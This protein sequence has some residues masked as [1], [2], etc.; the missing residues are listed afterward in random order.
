[1]QEGLEGQARG[2]KWDKSERDTGGLQSHKD[3]SVSRDDEYRGHSLFLMD[4]IFGRPVIMF[5][6]ECSC[7]LPYYYI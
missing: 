6:E 5:L 2:L 4:L 1:M 3:G 7:M